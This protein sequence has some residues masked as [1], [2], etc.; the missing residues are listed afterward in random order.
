MIYFLI[1]HNT[2][3]TIWKGKAKYALLFVSELM[4]KKMKYRGKD[5]SR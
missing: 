1:K 4:R 5:F 3:S 2:V